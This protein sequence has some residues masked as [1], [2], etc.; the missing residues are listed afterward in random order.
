MNWFEV[1]FSERKRTRRLRELETAMNQLLREHPTA[2]RVEDLFLYI[3][4]YIRCD[5]D[6]ENEYCKA[7]IRRRVH[8]G[9]QK[10]YDDNR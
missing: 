3:T 7:Y 6:L 10:H 4:N 1:W 2:Q 5:N 8:A 9:Y